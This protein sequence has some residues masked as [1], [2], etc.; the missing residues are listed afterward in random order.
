MEQEESA[1]TEEAPYPTSTD[2]TAD[3]LPR[4]WRNRIRAIMGQIAQEETEYQEVA[5]LAEHIGADY[6]DRFLVELL[7]NA[8]DQAT[9]AGLTDATV[10]VIRT[11]SAIAVLNEG[12][13]FNERGMRSITSAGI[14]AKDAQEALGNKGVGFKA[15]F[16]VTDRPEIY[17]AP[18]N[19]TS[20]MEHGSHWFQMQTNP[21]DDTQAETHA[22]EIIEQTF[23]SDN[24]LS[25]RI[26]ALAID[27]PSVSFVLDKLRKAA[28]FKFPRI[29]QRTVLDA[30][31]SEL[32]LSNDL[33]NNMS[34]MVVLPLL[35]GE[36]TSRK[37]DEILDTFIP[38]T[39][40]GS[41]LLF[42]KGVSRLELRDHV[43]HTT[44]VIERITDDHRDRLPRGA[45]FSEIY[46]RSE[47]I[48][49]SD[50]LSFESLWWLAQRRM[51]NNGDDGSTASQERKDIH[52]AVKKLPGNWG[53]VD[54]AYAA[55]ALPRFPNSEAHNHCELATDGKLCIG[56]PTTDLTGTPIWI[57]GPFHGN[58][59]RT[60]IDLDTTYNALI[61]N[62]AIILF[63][64]A[65]EIIKTFGDK[66]DKLA[67]TLYFQRSSGC[68][69]KALSTDSSLSSKK[70][71]LSSDGS[72]F[73][74]PCKIKIPSPLDSSYFHLFFSRSR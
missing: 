29:L 53:K 27:K 70:L 3:L 22:R 25:R 6:H 28:P 11:K 47:R 36:V 23:T 48:S 57:S 54:S 40:P 42:L 33:Q 20:F 24:L 35:T 71:V 16:Q 67:I 21:F 60:G 19:G 9:K 7:Q 4:L 52:E 44:W 63:W 59:S 10:I 46:L 61:F 17:T 14:S 15:V 55:V 74:S 30:R 50:S 32:E 64:D 1:P 72:T 26:Q 43:R 12:A 49:Q 45:H 31:I 38:D 39:R 68:L 34:T 8:E 66:G 56:L 13:P 69:A 18:E 51:G 65:I 73:L 62:E 41:V 58:V 37:I 2:A 5:S